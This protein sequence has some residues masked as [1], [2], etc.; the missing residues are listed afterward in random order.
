M[1]ALRL[2]GVADAEAEAVPA[3]AGAGD[4]REERAPVEGELERNR[5]EE[6][7]ETELGADA[8]HEVVV[9]DIVDESDLGGGT[10]VEVDRAGSDDEVVAETEAEV[11]DAPA[12]VGLE[13]VAG[14]EGVLVGNFSTPAGTDTEGARLRGSDDGKAEDGRDDQNDFFHDTYCL[15]GLWIIT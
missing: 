9:L 11:V 8:E 2:E 4:Q 12:E 3:E 7:L 15:K 13:E 14:T 10:D 1:V 6:I 5:V